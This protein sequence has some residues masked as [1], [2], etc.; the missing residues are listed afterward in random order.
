MP[1]GTQPHPE[2]PLSLPPAGGTA[3]PNSSPPYREPWASLLP[4]ETG[5]PAQHT[6]EVKTATTPQESSICFPRQ[7]GAKSQMRPAHGT[8]RRPPE[9]H[10]QD[11]MSPE[12]PLPPGTVR[13]QQAHPA[14]TLR[15]ERQAGL[16]SKREGQLG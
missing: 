7:G 12:R 2:L 13:E 8:S 9:I 15:S 14:R 10:Q 16:W 3:A 1:G 5:K 6:A 11:P 4:V